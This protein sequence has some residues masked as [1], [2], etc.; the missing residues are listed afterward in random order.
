METI[1]LT[2]GVEPFGVGF[3]MVGDFLENGTDRSGWLPVPSSFRDA[4]IQDHPWDIEGAGLGKSGRWKVESGRVGA[5]PVFA[6]A[7]ELGQGHGVIN[8]PCNVDNGRGRV[9]GLGELTDNEGHEVAGMQAVA[10]L[11]PLSPKT[12]VLKG[13]SRGPRMNPV[14]ED[15][16][17]RLAKLS[18]SSEYATAIDANGKIERQAIFQ[19]QQLRTFFGRSVQGY[20]R[21]GGEEFGYSGS[22]D[23]GILRFCVRW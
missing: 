6:P 4:G 22:A 9:G 20:R 5:K 2:Y 17:V 16:L 18:G 15:A 1:R 11:M 21:L 3:R 14:T 12:D 13:A 19:C 7:A 10:H 8:T 23:P